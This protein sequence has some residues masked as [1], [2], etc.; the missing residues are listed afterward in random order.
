MEPTKNR[1][2]GTTPPDNGVAGAKHIAQDAKQLA[3][4][5]VDRA[6]G[7][8]EERVTATQER[9]AGQIRNVATALRRTSEDLGDSFAAP[10]IEKAA[11]ALDSMSTGVKG[12]SLQDTMRQ[13]ERFARREPLLFLGATFAAGLL[14][15][16]FLKSTARH[17]SDMDELYGDLDDDYIEA[18]P[19]DRARDFRAMRGQSMEGMTRRDTMPMRA[20]DERNVGMSSGM[21]RGSMPGGGAYR[22]SMPGMPGDGATGGMGGAG[23]SLGGSASGVIGGGTSGGGTSGGGMSG[24]SGSTTV[25]GH[26]G[27]AVP[28]AIPTTPSTTPKV[29]SSEDQYAPPPLPPGGTRRS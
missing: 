13:T 7:V 4:D 8:A 25:T 16:R 5:V 6:K 14:A 17:D 10:L 15:A 27:G 24:M 12:A 22:S 20:M 21:N 18:G 3:S 2:S 11:R 26:A 19:Y 29:S 9:S 1:A 23:S 28:P